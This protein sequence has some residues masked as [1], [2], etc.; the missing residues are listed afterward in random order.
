M[1]KSVQSSTVHH[2]QWDI[3]GWVNGSKL[4][5][6]ENMMRMRCLRLFKYFKSTQLVCWSYA[7][8]DFDPSPWFSAHHKPTARA[9]DRL[10]NKWSWRM[11]DSSTDAVTGVTFSKAFFAAQCPEQWVNMVPF[12]WDM[13]PTWKCGIPYGIPRF[14]AVLIVG[15]VVLRWVCGGLCSNSITL[16][17]CLSIN[18]LIYL[19]TYLSIYLSI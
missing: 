14:M 2:S 11:M 1:V 4:G 15:V 10:P 17:L 5:A 16:S 6:H 12:S 3:W 8:F 7:F 9:S 18:L 13:Y 19:Y